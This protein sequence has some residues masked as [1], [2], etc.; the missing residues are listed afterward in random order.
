MPFSKSAGKN[1]RGVCMERGGGFVPV[2]GGGCA[3]HPGRVLANDASEWEPSET[4]Y[5]NQKPYSQVVNASTLLSREGPG[6]LAT[7][8]AHT[9]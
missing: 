5:K 8:S 1:E 6:S 7:L 9:T 3:N 4:S 2:H